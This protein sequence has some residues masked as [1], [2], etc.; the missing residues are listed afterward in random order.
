MGVCGL[1][2]RSAANIVTTELLIDTRYPVW[3]RALA[4]DR[5]HHRHE[6][7]EDADRSFDLVRHAPSRDLL[8][9]EVRKSHRPFTQTDDWAL[10]V[11][12][13][14]RT[15]QTVAQIIF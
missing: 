4:G 9:F 6:F 3:D 14:H 12:Y 11:V 1:F 10:H 2:F 13:L 8:I 15:P 7:A 5:R